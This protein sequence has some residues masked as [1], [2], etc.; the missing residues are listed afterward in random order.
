M[1]NSE[2][3][4]GSLYTRWTQRDFLKPHELTDYFSRLGTSN[5]RKAVNHILG[6]SNPRADVTLHDASLWNG[7]GGF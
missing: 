7:K 1:P 3:R 6:D 4:R 2:H 5:A